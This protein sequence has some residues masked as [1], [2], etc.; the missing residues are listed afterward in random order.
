MVV[1]AALGAAGTA[2]AA[3]EPS[4]LAASQIGSLSVVSA[5]Y[6][7][8]KS[9]DLLGVWIDETRP[10]TEKRLLD[11]TGSVDYVPFGRSG[12][13]VSRKRT[14]RTENCAE[15]GPNM[16][17]TLRAKAIGFGCS[18]GR[19]KPGHYTFV[20]TSVDHRKRLRAVASVGWE[21]RTAC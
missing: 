5:V 12:R 18:D 1:A 9:V 21:N 2:I 17:F 20:T 7:S 10:C 3:R 11:V 16:G 6:V 15:G 8:P 19:W 4:V 13:R 14:F